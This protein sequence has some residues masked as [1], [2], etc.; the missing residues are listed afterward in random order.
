MKRLG[1]PYFRKFVFYSVVA[2]LIAFGFLAFSQK[3]QLKHA[4]TKVVWVELPKGASEEIAIKIKESENLPQTT[5]QEQKQLPTE[6][7]KKA[8]DKE[9]Q[10][11]VAPKTETKPKQ[12]LR[13][14]QP[15]PIPK[16]LKKA[17]PKQADWQKALAVLE[18]K[19]KA[20]PPEAAQIK[21]KGE[22]F[23]YGTGSEPLLV[24]PD[25]PEKVAYVAKVRYKI[26]Q[27][28]VIPPAYIQ[29]PN[30]PKASI[31]LFINKEGAVMSMEWQNTSGNA[32]FDASCSRAVQR[33]SPLPVPPPRLEWEA[34]NE[35]Y[36]IA[37]DPS[38]KSKM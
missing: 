26:L 22:G 16:N 19:K 33:A 6:A 32:A 27:E 35:G 18:K 38:L 5:I 31:I 4:V 14:I 23:K 1:L 30:P 13:P 36:E 12:V 15:E 3:F 7:D 37:C 2:H 17:K 8:K 24:P 11:M 9:D 10:K 21:D 29:G 25:D 20:A 28:W 34:Y